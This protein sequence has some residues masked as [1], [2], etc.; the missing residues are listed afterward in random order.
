MHVLYILI[1]ERK[2]VIDSTINQP[3]LSL[4][5]HGKKIDRL[6]PSFRKLF[7]IIIII[8]YY[9]II[10]SYYFSIKGT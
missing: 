10:I 6:I 3:F 5:I 8:S 7:N 9:F 2:I 1:I 4:R